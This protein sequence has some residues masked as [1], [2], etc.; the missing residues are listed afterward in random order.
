[1]K[2]FLAALLLSIALPAAAADFSG[3]S[4]SA[5]FSQ[6]YAQHRIDTDYGGRIDQY[7]EKYEAIRDKRGKVQIRGTC[8]SACTL[9]LATV[10]YQDVCVGEYAKF[11]FHSAHNGF[12]GFAQEGTRLIWNMYP[13][14]VKT[15]LRARGWDGEGDTAEHPNLIYFEGTDFYPPCNGVVYT[16]EVTDQIKALGDAIEKVY[17]EKPE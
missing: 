15:K 7:I 4:G 16:K 2:K 14:W 10:P 11:A 12:G 8:I 6:V 13:E 3:V 9:V 5:D 17:P 1:L